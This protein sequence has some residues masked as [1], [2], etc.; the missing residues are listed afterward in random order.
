[1]NLPNECLICNHNLTNEIKRI[2]HVICPCGTR[3]LWSDDGSLYSIKTLMTD[4]FLV[5]NF[6]KNMCIYTGDNDVSFLP[7]LPYHITDQQL[8]TYLIFS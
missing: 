4:G 5:W 6:E 3:Y 1:M 7:W 8:K 2:D